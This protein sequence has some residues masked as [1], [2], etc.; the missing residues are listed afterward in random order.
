M[1]NN[2]ST[3]EFEMPEDVSVVRYINEILKNN[4]VKKNTRDW[5][6]WMTGTEGKE[7]QVLIIKNT[8]KIIVQE[9]LPNER[10]I[11]LLQRH[12]EVSKETAGRIILDIKTKLIPFAKV[13][14]LYEESLAIIQAGIKKPD[15]TNVEENAKINEA[16]KKFSEENKSKILEEISLPTDQASNNKFSSEKKGPDSYRE[17]IE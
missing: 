3:I 15:I 6:T 5:N 4:S 2:T 1:E 14:N 7:S 17:P 13:V 12:L 9:K 11:E 16:T 8:A 10:I